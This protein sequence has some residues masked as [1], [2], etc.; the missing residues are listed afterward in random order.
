MDNNNMN[1]IH[2]K[3]FRNANEAYEYMHDQ[4]I[5][6]GVDFAGTK[7]IFA[8]MLRSNSPAIIKREAPIAKMPTNA[9]S[10]THA[11]IPIGFSHI[12]PKVPLIEVSVIKVMTIIIKPKTDPNSG[13][14]IDLLINPIS[15]M[16]SSDAICPPKI[17]LANRYDLPDRYK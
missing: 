7:A 1:T 15:R 11:W 13:L 3:V 16:R 4:I 10:S 17:N 5:Q 9:A 8:P 14:D 12:A 6:N 2:N